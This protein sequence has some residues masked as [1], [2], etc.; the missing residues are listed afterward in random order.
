MAKNEV[1]L[2]VS[3]LTKS[4]SGVEVLH[5][6]QFQ[7]KKGEVH[8]LLGENGAGKSTFMKILLGIHKPD[9]GTILFKG[10]KTFFKEPFDALQAGISMIHQEINLIP[11]MSIAENIWV[12]REKQFYR[13]GFIDKKLQLS[14][15][16]E[17]LQEL[18]VDM[19]PDTMVKELSIASMQMVELVRAVSYRSDIIIMDE[20]TSALTQ[21]EI[22]VLYRVV[23]ELAKK[24]TAVIFISHKLEEVF[25]ICDRV[26]ILRD[27]NYIETR[28]CKQTDMQTL[29]K[30]IV[31]RELNQIFPKEDV[32]IG[33]KVLEVTNLTRRGVFEN[34]SFHIKKGEIVGFCGL[35]GAGRTEIMRGL[36]GVDPVDSG[37]VSVKGRQRRIRS[38]RDAIRCGLGMVTE[39][40]LALG[41]IRILSIKSN[42]TLV[43][44]KKLCA[45]GL[46]IKKKEEESRCGDMMRRMEVKASSMNQA[47]SELSGGNQQKVIL[48]KWLMNQPDILILDEPTRGIDVGSKSEIYRVI[49]MLA[50]QGMAILMVSSELP[51]V[52]GMSD[53]ILV[54][55]E[56]RIVAEHKRGEADQELLI[57]EEFGTSGT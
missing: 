20:P 30:L 33:E 56:G 50:R 38:P 31:G 27:G 57:K 48:G 13:H 44:L 3:G 18:D 8:A 45:A 12:G 2:E 51:E 32:E 26:T 55:R 54:I 28:A 36:F 14:K 47:I 37:S 42:M 24:G 19:E 10:K 9:T 4:F 15:T 29:I 39:D 5:G 16:R 40:R 17:L 49:S 11:N 25:E 7:L 22:D 41:G 43:Y 35:M 6:I 34:V 53:R 46:F 1:V 23:R 52:L 21:T